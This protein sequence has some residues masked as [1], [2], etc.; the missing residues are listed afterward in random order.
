MLGNVVIS[1]V[2]VGAGRQWTL[3]VEHT[4]LLPVP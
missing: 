4:A 1:R 3:K 2:G